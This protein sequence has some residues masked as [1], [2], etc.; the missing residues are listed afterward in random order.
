MTE[1]ACCCALQGC[2]ACAAVSLQSVVCRRL[3][4]ACARCLQ[5]TESAAKLEDA[6][7]GGGGRRKLHAVMTLFTI[8]T[9]ITVLMRGRSLACRRPAE[10]RSVSS[11]SP[12]LRAKINSVAMASTSEYSILSRHRRSFFSSP[13]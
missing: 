12:A 7:R 3:H 13:R 2:I 10:D 9:V 5:V 8:N 6:A 1:V 4:S 11:F